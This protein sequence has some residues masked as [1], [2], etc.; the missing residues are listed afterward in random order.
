M[1]EV[2][3]IER[4]TVTEIRNHVTKFSNEVFGERPKTE[5]EG[6]IRTPLDRFCRPTHNRS[7]TSP[8]E[9]N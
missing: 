6:G 4:S 7:A 5:G 1:L 9:E 8:H 3:L 2:P